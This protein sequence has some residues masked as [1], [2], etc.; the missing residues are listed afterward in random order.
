MD[1][2]KGRGGIQFTGGPKIKW[3]TKTKKSKSQLFS[4]IFCRNKKLFPILIELL[5]LFV[6]WTSSLLSTLF[7]KPLY[8]SYLGKYKQYIIH[9][10]SIFTK[11]M[12]F[13]SIILKW[14]YYTVTQNIFCSTQKIIYFAAGGLKKVVFILIFCYKADNEANLIFW[15]FFAP[16]EAD[17]VVD[18]TNIFDFFSKLCICLLFYFRYSGSTKHDN[19]LMRKY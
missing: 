11:I 9:S 10:I 17:R 14:I 3:K 16:L 6:C 18:I 7:W 1:K 19:F 12:Y 4:L 15:I 8:I 13:Y 5:N 2:D